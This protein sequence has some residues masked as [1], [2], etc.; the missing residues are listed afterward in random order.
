MRRDTQLLIWVL[1]ILCA[2]V[3]LTPGLAESC[4]NITQWHVTIARPA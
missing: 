3:I 4:R 2:A 1:I